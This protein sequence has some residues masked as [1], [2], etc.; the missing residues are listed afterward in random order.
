[1]TSYMYEA[2]PRPVQGTKTRTTAGKAKYREANDTMVL[3]RQNI[4]FDRRVI[5]G[6]TYAAQIHPVATLQLNAQSPLLRTTQ[7]AATRLPQAQRQ[8]ARRR[9]LGQQPQPA[10]QPVSGRTHMM[11]QTDDYLEELADQ[12]FEADSATQTD[13]VEEVTVPPLYMPAKPLGNDVAT[14][15]EEGELFDFELAVEPTL[16]VIVGKA[17]E[18]AVM[19]VR[20]EEEIRMWKEQR[21]RL[22]QER[23][24]I[25]AEAQRMEAH[26]RRHHEE[27]ERRLA[28]ERERLAREAEVARK[29]AA[30]TA[31]RDL[32]Q[33]LQSGV[34]ERLVEAGHLYDPVRK[35]VEG[36]FM[37]WLVQTSTK[38]LVQ[39]H[40]SRQQLDALIQQA[41]QHVHQ[42]V[43]D[44]I[45]MEAEAKAE[46]ERQRLEA[47]AKA[48]EEAREKARVEEEERKAAEEAAAR[49]AEEAERREREENGE[50]EEDEDGEDEEE[51][52]EEDEE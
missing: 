33:N 7:H 47:I 50:D 46:Q 1:M 18:Q 31:A 29:A 51:E 10:S 6:N 44:K 2:Q 39:A 9:L 15:I 42:E 25:M 48:E 52:D 36:I 34:V 40:Q 5:R 49:E 26:S 4:H 19:E 17:M 32:L 43:A 41:V 13:V 23:N 22:Q 38:Q 3:P 30:R 28:Q 12:I 35:E 20:E 27:K 45:R 21:D 14:S 16:E 8:A 37:P 11:V 24:Q